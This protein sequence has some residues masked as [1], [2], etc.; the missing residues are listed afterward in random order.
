MTESVH[1]DRLHKRFGLT[2]REAAMAA[3]ARSRRR[4]SGNICPLR[5]LPIFEPRQTSAEKQAHR[6]G[7]EGPPAAKWRLRRRAV[8]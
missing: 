7:L 3:S 4:E 6:A 2:P 5:D 1:L 8:R